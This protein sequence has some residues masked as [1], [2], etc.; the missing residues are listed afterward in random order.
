M[1]IVNKNTGKIDKMRNKRN[2][3]WNK[4]NLKKNIN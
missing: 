4:M 1:T 2:K 3:K